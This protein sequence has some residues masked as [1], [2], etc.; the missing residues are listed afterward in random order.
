[1]KY[2]LVINPGS[3]STKLALYSTESLEIY[4]EVVEHDVN[5]L[6]SFDRI[7][8][9]TPIRK[10]AIINALRIKGVKKEDLAA[11]AG[12][13]GLLKPIKGGTYKVD[14][15]MV[16]DLEDAIR[17][18][19]AANLG[20]LLA[21]EVAD[22]A[23]VE[24]YIVDPVSCD[25]M[26]E[27]ARFTGLKDEE[28]GSLAHYLNIKGVTR[29]I[30]RENGFDF[31]QDNFIVAH[32]GSGFSIG[33]L[34]KGRL[35]DVNN[36]NHGGPFSPERV[37]TLPNGVLLKYAFSG[38]YSL[39]SLSKLLQ[40]NGGLL[41]HLGTNDAR[42]VEKRIGEGDEYAKKVYE[43]MAYQIA[44]EIGA[45]AAVLKGDVKRIIITGGLAYSS[46]M[47]TMIREYVEFIAPL[48]IVPGEYEMK[49]LYEGVRRILAKEENALIYE[50]E[51]I[52]EKF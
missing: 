33:P 5:E 27:L 40:R 29:K 19:H 22:D 10:E 3:T 47:T 12:R 9:Q 14:S 48:E 39:K 7:I 16:K 18:E 25:E 37:G 1:M 31:Y 34:S 49:S 28:R 35:I 6:K 44:K 42:I 43:A 46:M 26:N 21:K 32:L 2:V 17:G 13:G 41:S 11:V 20:A 51:V 50:E 23:G 8:E 24:A 38:E 30:C 36:A 4:N 45:C 15:V 52:S